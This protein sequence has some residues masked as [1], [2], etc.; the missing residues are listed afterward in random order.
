MTG[1]TGGLIRTCTLGATMGLVRLLSVSCLVFCLH[2]HS[3]TYTHTHTHARTSTHTDTHT[4]T[5]HSL[6]LTSF[7]SNIS[8]A[9]CQ[10]PPN[11]FGMLGV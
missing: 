4:H 11:Y 9:P 3:H 7:P 5:Q 8:N 1:L 6:Y 10:T 2:T